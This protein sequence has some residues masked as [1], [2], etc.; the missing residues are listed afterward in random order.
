MST[1]AETRTRKVVNARSGGLCEVR[2]PAVCTG[3]GASMHHRK[4]P[5]R[6]WSPSNVLHACGDGT[7]GC[8]G[9]IEANPTAAHDRGLWLMGAE[10]SLIMPA[11]ICWRGI[12]DWF[13]LTDTGG[14]SW[15]GRGPLAEGPDPVRLQR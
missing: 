7:T 14:I 2:I 8:H 6:V 10:D 3:I 9:W 13:R 12:T 5:G 15:P 11:V 4:K 1:P